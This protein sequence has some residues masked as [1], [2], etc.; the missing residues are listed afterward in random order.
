MPVF[1]FSQNLQFEIGLIF[2]PFAWDLQYNADNHQ[3]SIFWKLFL[4]AL[5]DYQLVKVH[6]TVEVTWKKEKVAIVEIWEENWESSSIC[7]FIFLQI[8]YLL[9]YVEI[10]ILSYTRK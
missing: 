6:R 1:S 4:W 10:I 5:E 8:L 9:E 7:I 2:M 3:N